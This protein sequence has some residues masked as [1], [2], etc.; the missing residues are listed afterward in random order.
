MRIVLVVTGMICLVGALVLSFERQRWTAVAPTSAE[1]SGPEIPVGAVLSS[2]P[3]L[4]DIAVGEYGCMYGWS[5]SQEHHVWLQKGKIVHLGSCGFGDSKALSTIQR[6][7][8]GSWKMMG[9]TYMA[10][11]A[12]STQIL[13]GASLCT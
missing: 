13:H 9:I 2:H 11:F 7:P 5:V 6:L 1:A 3:D 12:F 10:T 8:D 4:D